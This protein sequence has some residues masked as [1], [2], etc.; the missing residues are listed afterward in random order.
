MST[1]SPR[2]ITTGWSQ[3][4]P[5]PRAVKPLSKAVVLDSLRTTLAR[6]ANRRIT[7]LRYKMSQ[8]KLTETEAIIGLLE[9][10]LGVK[11]PRFVDKG[12]K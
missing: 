5:R 4:G 3:I 12:H 7:K 1:T 8:G 11:A 6:E 2:P 10:H 9:C